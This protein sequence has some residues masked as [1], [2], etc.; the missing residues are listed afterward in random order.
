MDDK[1]FE[2]GLQQRRATLGADYVDKSLAGA[3][4]FSRPFQEALTE[5]CWGFAWGDPAL[6]AKTRS[7]INLGMIAAL[8]K[9]NE[10]ELHCRGALRNGVTEKELR[11]VIHIVAAYCG[12]PAALSCL[13]SA[14]KIL[15]E[16]ESGG[17]T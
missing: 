3:D 5:F 8:G 9:M 2:L 13:H 14:R 16:N 17:K 4:D 15:K 11:A 1:R 12:F 6:D 10:W 7:L